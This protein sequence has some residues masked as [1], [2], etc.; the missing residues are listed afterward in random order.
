MIL[1]RLCHRLF[2]KLRKRVPWMQYINLRLSCFIAT[3]S[4]IDRYKDATS[5]RH[6]GGI[7]KMKCSVSRNY[8]TRAGYVCFIEPTRTRE[9]VSISTNYTPPSQSRP[10]SRKSRRCVRLY[11]TVPEFSSRP[12]LQ[13]IQVA[14]IFVTAIFSL[15]PPMFRT[16]DCEETIADILSW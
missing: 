5:E 10:F 11:I 7:A 1:I 9:C 12:R 13:I 14:P 15:Y 4:A 3:Q 16:R 6:Y 8:N 2:K